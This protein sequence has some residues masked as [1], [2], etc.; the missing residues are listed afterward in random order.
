MAKCIKILVSF[1]VCVVF[2]VGTVHHLEGELQE[3]QHNTSAM[4]FQ[5]E[6]IDYIGVPQFPSSPVA[7][8]VDGLQF[9]HVS[10]FRLQRV[11]LGQYRVSLKNVVHLLSNIEASLLRHSRRICDTTL[12]HSHQPSSEYYIFALRHIII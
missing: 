2:L 12:A 1:I 8:V 4:T 9:Q 5:E 11:Q 6:S 3:R 7:E 10:S